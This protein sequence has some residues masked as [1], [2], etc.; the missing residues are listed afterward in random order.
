MIETK[1]LLKEIIIVMKR[2]IWEPGNGTRYDLVYGPFAGTGEFLLCWMKKGSSGGTCI[3][4]KSGD[5]LHHN[6]IEEKMVSYCL[7]ILMGMKVVFLR[8]IVLSW[9]RKQDYV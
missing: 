1:P 6:Y 2:F 9:L 3:L 8:A 7:F 5:F 4:W